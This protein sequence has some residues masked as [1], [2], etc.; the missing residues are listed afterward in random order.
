MK[1]VDI[2][3]PHAAQHA[4]G[5]LPEA[6]APVGGLLVVLYGLPGCENLLPRDTRIGYRHTDPLL[7]GHVHALLILG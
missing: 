5:E 4:P 3:P 6:P 2:A 1:F 7:A